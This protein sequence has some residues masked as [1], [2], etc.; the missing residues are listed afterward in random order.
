ML[1]ERCPNLEKIELHTKAVTNDEDTGVSNGQRRD[2]DADE[3]GPASS[4]KSRSPSEERRKFLEE[5]HGLHKFT[6]DV[7]ECSSLHARYIR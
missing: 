1:A 3:A 6:L 7:R 5:L 4:A 2:L